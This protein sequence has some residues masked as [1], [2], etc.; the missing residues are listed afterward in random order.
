MTTSIDN[1][2]APSSAGD[3]LDLG[4]LA[5]LHPRL[6]HIVMYTRPV[7]PICDR[8]KILFKAAKLPVV[9]VPISDNDEAYRL[10]SEELHVTRS[11]IVLVHNTFQKPT[12]FSGFDSERARIVI[13][14]MFDR[15]EILSRSVG[16][17]SVERY[18]EGLAASIEPGEGT[19]FIRPETFASMAAN[20]LGHEDASAA[21]R[22]SPTLLSN[23]RSQ[24]PPLLH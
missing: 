20:H 14:S 6:P 22:R 1:I 23:S 4:G 2:S 15:L 17:L 8:L 9:A 24:V 16:S 10:F 21:H 19:P 13:N 3:G 18:I 5:P 12:Y 7:C 11:P